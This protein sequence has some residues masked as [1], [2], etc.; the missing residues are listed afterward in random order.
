[1]TYYFDKFEDAG[2]AQIGDGGVSDRQR[3]LSELASRLDEYEEL[4]NEISA[5]CDTI[6]SDISADWEERA[7]SEIT[8]AGYQPNRKHGVAIN[9]TPLAEAKIVPKIVDDKVL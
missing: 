7:L 3:L 4:A 9:V 2:Q 1:M 8:T 5:A 6:S